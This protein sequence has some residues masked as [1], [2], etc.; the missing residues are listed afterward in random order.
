MRT[1]GRRRFSASSAFIAFRRDKL[2]DFGGVSVFLDSVLIPISGLPLKL[3]HNPVLDGFRLDPGD[4]M[5]ASCGGVPV[6][7]GFL[8]FFLPTRR[9]CV[10]AGV[11]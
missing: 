8:R 10:R 4:F 11:F 6:C 9:E 7:T 5:A 2:R 3:G 1:A